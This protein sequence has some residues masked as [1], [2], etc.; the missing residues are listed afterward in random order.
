VDGTIQ[1]FAITTPIVLPNFSNALF[2]ML[3]MSCHSGMDKFTNIFL[4]TTD[5]MS[6]LAISL[7][8]HVS[9]LS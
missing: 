1:K 3:L 8:I 5:M 6:L 7:D 9:T 2:S 4:M